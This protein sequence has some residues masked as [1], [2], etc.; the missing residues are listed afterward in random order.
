VDRRVAVAVDA[1]RSYGRGL[2]LG[3]GDFIERRGGWST[4]VELHADGRYD[5]G[6]LKGWTGDGVLAY[7]EDPALARRLARSGLPIVELFGHHLDLGLP[8]VGNDDEAIGRLAAEHLRERGLRRFAFGGYEGEAWVERRFRGFAGSLSGCPAPS[9]VTVD[10]SPGIPARWERDQA[11]LRDWI[12]GLPS[13]CGL[14]AC[15]DRLA[16]RILDACRRAGRRVPDEIAV[17]GVD[18]DPSLCRL[19]D[20]SLSS[21]R[22]DPRR[23]GYEAARLLD[24]LMRR[25]PRRLPPPLL[26]PPLGVSARRSTDVAAVGD[27]VV[28]AAMKSIRSRAT[29][30]LRVEDLLGEAHL[31]RA[32]FYRRFSA[33]LGRTPHEELRRRRLERVK[34][35]L[36]ETR[37]TLEEI[38]ART[39]F[40]HP[41][42][43]SASFKRETGRTPGDFRRNG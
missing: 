23:I 28:A 33:A 8:V 43:L 4:Y 36:R 5:P 20:P 2:L 7:L 26:V 35:L 39:G 6:W 1:S 30:G 19:G 11:R 41:E 34:E 42:Y 22:D 17:L 15:S 38:A 37:L 12:R 13:P 31:S 27:P 10:R 24:R 18:D 14:L 3:I 16:Q 29:E 21:I 40:D 32:A 9:R 25:R